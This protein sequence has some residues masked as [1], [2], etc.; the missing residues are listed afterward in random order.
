MGCAI[1]SEKYTPSATWIVMMGNGDV[2]GVD[3]IGVGRLGAVVEGVV[4]ER[5]V[6][7]L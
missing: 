6:L 7:M 1:Q 5:V 2:R 4:G 3:V